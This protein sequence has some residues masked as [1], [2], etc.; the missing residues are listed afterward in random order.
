MHIRAANIHDAA[1]IAH[2]HV[3]SWRTT[4]KGIVPEDFL[5]SLSSAQCEQWWR[6]VLADPSNVSYVYVAE[7]DRG[8]IVGFVYGGSERNG[9]PVY[10]GELYSIYVLAPHHGQGIGRQLTIT[11][12]KRLRQDGITALLLW[13]LAVN[14][15]RQFYERL[16]GRPVYAKTVTISDL[17][18]IEV[19][20]GW[21]DTHALL[22]QPEP[23]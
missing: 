8:H 19:A 15:S 13:V 18:L 5:A 11:L 9:D 6:Q 12:V 4:Y 22:E 10:M 7:D 21:R 23:S 17:P 16:G 14:P 2:V 20:Y 1:A 3:E